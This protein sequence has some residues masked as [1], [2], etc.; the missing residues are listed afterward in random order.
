MANDSGN[1]KVEISGLDKALPS[2]GAIK[3]AL[4]KGIQ[5][6][7]KEATKQIQNGFDSQ[8]TPGGASWVP[9]SPAYARQKA[10][11]YGGPILVAT[12]ALRQSAISPSVTIQAGDDTVSATLQAT[13]PKAAYHQFGTGRIPARPFFALEGEAA[14]AVTKTITETVIKDLF[15]S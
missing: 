13:D 2:G 3:D 10:K 7:V 8:R 9:L 11:R 15:S 5:A 12:G 4:E 14:D 6:G 1:L